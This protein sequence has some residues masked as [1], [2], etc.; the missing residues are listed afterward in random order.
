MNDEGSDTTAIITVHNQPTICCALTFSAYK[1]GV[2]VNI[3]NTILSQNN[4]FSRYSQFVEAVNY[5]VQCEIPLTTHLSSVADKLNSIAAR[6]SLDDSRRKKISFFARQLK[7]MSLSSFSM[8]DYCFAIEHYPKTK[9]ENLQEFLVLP[10]KSKIKTIISAAEESVV[11]KEMF[12]TVNCRQ[13]NW[14]KESRI[15][16]STCYNLQQ[17]LLCDN[18]ILTNS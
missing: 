8:A 15:S 10:S 3:P 18:Y 5:V 1:H 16:T 14:K 7:V 6:E 9:Y 11:L 2:K 13:L 17:Q 12:R 4:G